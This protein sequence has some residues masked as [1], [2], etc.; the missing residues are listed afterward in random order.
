MKKAI[1]YLLGIFIATACAK[2]SNQFEE[3]RFDDI[4]S[5]DLNNSISLDSIVERTEIIRFTSGSDLIIGKIKSVFESSGHIYLVENNRIL[6]FN[7]N[8]KFVNFIGK[9]GKGPGEFITPW[10]IDIDEK[11]Q[12]IY[13]M[14]YFGRKMLRYLFNGTFDKSFTL[15]ETLNVNGFR[16]CQDKI[17]YTSNTNSI[18][19][20]LYISDQRKDELKEIS[21]R[22][23]EMVAGEGMMELSFLM[24]PQDQPLLFHYFNDTVF[25]IVNEQL[26]PQYLLKLGK[27]KFGFD[28]MIVETDKKPN[29][30][31]AQVYDII[32]CDK[33]TFIRYG[34][35]ML[36]NAKQQTLI[37]G[38]YCNNFSCSSPCV[39]FISKERPL[40]NILIDQKI[41]AGY[42][43]TL[44]RTISAI[45][46]L[47]AEPSFDISEDDNP[48]LVKYYLK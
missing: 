46:V 45:D 19:P 32:R 43:N 21:S 10:R 48:I 9:K 1:F 2:N 17:I 4:H 18:T 27:L 11:N 7:K 42:E 8:G 12:H 3:I 16:L 26:K 23:R 22:S 31:R 15:P 28:E 13:V 41:S 5:I 38:F 34:V 36:N 35:T 39:N 25:S 24:G 37:T 29:G 44:I 20:E 14:D 30:P 47:D 6:Q 33:F 40:F